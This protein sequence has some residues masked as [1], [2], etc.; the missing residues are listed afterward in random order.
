MSAPKFETIKIN[1]TDKVFIIPK[2]SAKK[3]ETKELIIIKKLKTVVKA[4][5]GSTKKV[6]TVP[7]KDDFPT[8]AKIY[9]TVVKNIPT[10]VDKIKFKK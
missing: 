3:L 2:I 10:N 5:N 8:S 6:N 4:T 7:N 9:G 1:L